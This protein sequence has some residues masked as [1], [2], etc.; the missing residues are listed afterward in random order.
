MASPDPIKLLLVESA[1]E[2]EA[3]VRAAIEGC[4][5]HPVDVTRAAS[6]EAGR[7]ALQVEPFDCALVAW[8]P[9][10]GSDRGRGR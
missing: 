1:P 8:K 2:V 9:P 4:R 6:H 3:Q 7:I 10:W 5:L